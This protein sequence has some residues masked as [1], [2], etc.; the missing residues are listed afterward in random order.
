MESAQQQPDNTGSNVLIDYSKQQGFVRRIVTHHYFDNVMIVVIIIN[1]IFLTLADPRKDFQYAYLETAD[2]TFDVIFIVECLAKIMGTSIGLYFS[3]QWHYVDFIIVLQAFYSTVLLNILRASGGFNGLISVHFLSAFRIARLLRILRTIRIL[4]V[5]RQNTTKRGPRAR[6]ASFFITLNSTFDAITASLGD[7]LSNLALLIGFLVFFGVVGKIQFLRQLSNRCIAS[8]WINNG[9]VANNYL[10]YR[11][12]IQPIVFNVT[13]SEFF[14]FTYNF[15]VCGIDMG[16]PCADGKECV[17]F[18][19]ATT[20]SSYFSFASAKEAFVTNFIAISLRGWGDLFWAL[21]D[22]DGYFGAYIY[23]ILVIGI[24]SLVLLNIFPAITFKY[25]SESA[26]NRE[27]KDWRQRYIGDS[28]SLTDFDLMLWAYDSGQAFTNENGEN[29]I[30]NAA[31]ASKLLDSTDEDHTSA[32][33][34]KKNKLEFLMPSCRPCDRFRMI[35]VK[36]GGPFSIVKDSD[37]YALRVLRVLRLIRLFRLVELIRKGNVYAGQSR[38]IGYVKFVDI[39]TKFLTPF[40]EFIF[41]FSLSL[42]IFAIIAMNVFGTDVPSTDCT[43]QFDF[44][45]TQTFSMACRLDFRSF[46]YSVRTLF[47]IYSQDSWYMILWNTI[48]SSGIE[49]ST[50]FF[51]LWIFT[52]VWFLQAVLFGSMIR[53]MEQEAKYLL[54]Y[55]GSIYERQNKKIVVARNR[56]IIRYYFNKF[57]INVFFDK[58]T[59]ASTRVVRLVG[60]DLKEVVEVYRTWTFFEPS[61]TTTGFLN[62]LTDSLTS[63]FFVSVSYAVVVLIFAFIG[64]TMWSGRFGSCYGVINDPPGIYPKHPSISGLYPAGASRYASTMKFPEGCSGDAKFFGL[65]GRYMWKNPLDTFDDLGHA[66]QSVF[67]IIIQNEWHVIMFRAIDSSDNGLFEQPI[68]DSNPSAFIFFYI[69]GIFAS[70]LGFLFIAVVWYHYLLSTLAPVGRDIIYGVREALWISYDTLLDR[71]TL[72]KS[73][74]PSRNEF[75][76]MLYTILNSPRYNSFYLITSGFNTEKKLYCYL[77]QGD[78]FIRFLRFGLFFKKFVDLIEKLL[79]SVTS[80]IPLIAV[81]MTLVLVYGVVGLDVT[82]GQQP[83]YGYS[84]YE[85]HYNFNSLFNAIILLTNT[86]TGNGWTGYVDNYTTQI[87]DTSNKFLVYVYFVSYYFLFDTLRKAFALMMIYQ[88]QI[89][90]SDDAQ[91][92]NGMIQN[93]KLAWNNIMDDGVYEKELMTLKELPHFLRLLHT[94]LGLR[95]KGRIVSYLELNRFMMKVITHVP[96][97]KSSLE[98]DWGRNLM[99]EWDQKRR[100]L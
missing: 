3:N 39:L 61:R 80:L 7:I 14:H 65:N 42:F 77:A 45:A 56:Q 90:N 57:K 71:I 86:A 72:D 62:A 59:I 35:F 82:A 97:V 41:L 19:Y 10:S 40:I 24:C 64:L 69:V 25:L 29:I 73:T 91:L 32:T 47:V 48:H 6:V 44:L 4:K 88:Y 37:L 98:T 93:F 83:Q 8:K 94:P 21:R 74:I 31:P 30:E 51:L 76:R 49:Q 55:S 36:V 23:L 28:S 33:S 92:S 68:V 66:M 85:T 13:D 5:L 11:K 1:C 67:R 81:T 16:S 87:D 89:Q 43:F 20:T 78:C 70:L 50:L 38:T 79:G 99:Y 17:N 9:E 22:A 100:A 84:F 52:S 54:V 63:L 2:I 27:K 95:K 12:S 75:K 53:I 46:V 58:D 15:D 96:M 18:A 34:N 60:D 26:H